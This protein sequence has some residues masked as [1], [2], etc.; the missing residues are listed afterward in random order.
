M[1]NATQDKKKKSKEKR[2]SHRRTTPGKF[3]C[4]S[5]TV[6]SNC[7]LLMR[8]GHP[9]SLLLVTAIC[10]WWLICLL[11]LLLPSII[12]LFRISVNQLSLGYIERRVN[13]LWYRFNLCAQFLLNLVESKSKAK[14][15]KKKKTFLRMFLP[16]KVIQ[17]R[18]NL[19]PGWK[20]RLTAPLAIIRTYAILPFHYTL[21]FTN[22][23]VQIKSQL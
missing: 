3:L 15:K 20:E 23:A 2:Y 22:W 6:L 1:N 17:D 13:S 4:I 5:F 7:L 8:D 10:T 19:R 11:L 21:L 14:I 18:R 16:S 12:L 9:R